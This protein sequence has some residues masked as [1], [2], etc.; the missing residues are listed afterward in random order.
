MILRSLITSVVLS[1]L[2]AFPAIAQEGTEEDKLIATVNGQ[3][4]RA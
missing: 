2:L 3:E 1:A 4:I